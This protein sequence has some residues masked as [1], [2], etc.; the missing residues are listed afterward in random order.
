M[1][2]EHNGVERPPPGE[3]IRPQVMPRYARAL[4]RHKDD[5]LL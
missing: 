1:E 3:T 2:Y 5:R 4:Q